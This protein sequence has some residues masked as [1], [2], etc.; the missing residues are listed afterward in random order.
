MV[1]HMEYKPPAPTLAVG[2]Y[3]LPK[4]DNARGSALANNRHIG[5]SVHRY[6]GRY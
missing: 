4:R 5:T 6:L 2:D 3:V 1:E